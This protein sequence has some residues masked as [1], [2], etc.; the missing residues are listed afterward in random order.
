[1][2]VYVAYVVYITEM[3]GSWGGISRCLGRLDIIGSGRG[4]IGGGTR[5]LCEYVDAA[6]KTVA[7]LSGVNSLRDRFRDLLRGLWR[8][9]NRRRGGCELL[10]GEREDYRFS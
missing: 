6:P 10:G 4:S 7:L 8:E 9:R 1:M 3:V 5:A 2:H